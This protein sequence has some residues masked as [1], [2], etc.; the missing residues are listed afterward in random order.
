MARMRRCKLCG[1]DVKANV[2]AHVCPHGNPCRYHCN[3]DGM[4]TDWESP[5]CDV[6]R[7]VAEEPRQMILEL[8]DDEWGYQDD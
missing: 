3:S 6:C 7:G 5:E 1:A 8:T 2:A 4:P